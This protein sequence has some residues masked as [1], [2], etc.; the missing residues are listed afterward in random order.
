MRQVKAIALHAELPLR[1][2]F[3]VALGLALLA[4]LGGCSYNEATTPSAAPTAVV[5]PSTD[6]VVTYPTGRYELRGD[7][8]AVTPYYWVWVQAGAPV[9]TL[10]PLPQAP[11]VTSTPVPPAPIVTS[12]P[13]VV[14]PA[15]RVATYQ[16]GRYELVGQGTTGSPYYWVW[17]P[18]GATPPPPPP[19]PRALQT[20]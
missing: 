5:V 3:L 2:V 17:I 20:Q 13:V 11:I 16:T 7:G 1:E 15:Q 6:R 8:T 9:V 18:S 10:P 4:M 19:L 12:A 14:A